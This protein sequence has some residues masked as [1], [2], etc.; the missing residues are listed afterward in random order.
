M[1]H[2]ITKSLFLFLIIIFLTGFQTHAQ[3]TGK[4]VLMDIAE[5][6]IVI[7]GERYTF[8]KHYRTLHIDKIEMQQL[9][10]QAPMESSSNNRSGQ[11]I[12]PMPMPD[13]SISNFR[14]VETFVMHPDLAA[15]FPEIKTYMGQGID[16]PNAT[17]RLDM[18][19]LEFH[20]MVLSPKGP[21]FIDPY[22]A[23]TTDDYICYYKKDLTPSVNFICETDQLSNS[24][25]KSI[26]TVSGQKSAG[27]QLRTYRLALAC[28]G[29][30]AATKGGT[31]A[32]ALAGM[33]TSMNRVD[34]VY[35]TEVAIR[36]VMVPNDT[37]LIYT[38]SS[39]DPYTNNNGSTML[40]QNVSTCN[41]VIGSS[42]YDIGHV[43][44]TGGGGIAG[45]GVV[46]GSSK[47]NGVTGSSN[48]VGDG[49]DIDYVAHEMGH[50]FGGNHTFNSTTGS[51]GGGN[52]ASSA[53]YEPGSGITVMAYAGICGSDDLAPH[54]IAYFHVKSFDEIVNYTTTGNG[55]S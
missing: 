54:S 9:L 17:I 44:S 55:N 27:T 1:K 23:G 3:S 16:D 43:F 51:C 5:S 15:K 47:A 28:T 22:S 36:M 42:N 41:S 30:Y 31:K 48:P 50:Q 40:G 24:L 26:S 20:A 25:N 4:R 13:G 12:F 19:P 29:E 14:I 6:S 49:F 38:N 33:V 21:V 10:S 46:C 32:G 11:V 18:T 39:T 52:R 2:N 35:E 8:P 34:G 45:L 37:L 7:K 53:A